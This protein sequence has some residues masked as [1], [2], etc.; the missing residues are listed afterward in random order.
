MHLFGAYDPQ[1]RCTNVRADAG[2]SYLVVV[3][4]ETR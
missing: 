2:D 3:I 1:V 4:E